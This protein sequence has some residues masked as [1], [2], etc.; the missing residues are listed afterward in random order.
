MSP[1]AALMIIGELA[2]AAAEGESDLG[3]DETGALLA[4]RFMELASDQAC[5]SPF[6][7]LRVFSRVIGVTPHQYLIRARLRRAARLLADEGRAI[8]DVAFEVGFGDVSNFVRTFHRAAGVS[9]R[10]FRRAARGDP[11]IL[12]DRIARSPLS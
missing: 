7:F 8:A 10:E 3:L 6:H 9:P 1:I 5:A 2:Q 4:S 11:K 12:Q